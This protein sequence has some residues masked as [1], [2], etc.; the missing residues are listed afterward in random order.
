MTTVYKLGGFVLGLLAVFG[1]A[2]GAGRLVGPS[3]IA[4]PTEE[5][6][7]G[8][9]SSEE[10]STVPGGL[11]I[12]QDGYR[13]QLIDTAPQSFSFRLLGPDGSA[14]TSYTTTHDK[15]LHLILVRRDLSGFQHLHPAMA[16]DGV[17]SLPLEVAEPGQYRVFA[18]FQPAARNDNLVL[19]A[20]VVI[21][22]DYQP[23]ALPAPQR[24]STV[25][26]YTVTVAGDLEAGKL[27]KLTL[28]VKQGD[29]E[30]TDLEP[31]LGAFGHLVALRGGDLAYLHVHPEE[32]TAAGPRIV[33]YAEVP[34]AGDYRLYLDFQHGGVVRTA[35]FTM[36]AHGKEG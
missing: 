26:G 16:A 27:S 2:L 36:T 22:G 29:T 9:H 25:D 31:Y 21:A 35:E 20:D 13:L 6:G 7:D 11:Q 3:A 18:D 15:D 28:T 19:G 34:S 32:S 5:H 14:V 30:V 12:A 33:F 10:V 23:G 4:A 24:S 1:V 17:W 8:G